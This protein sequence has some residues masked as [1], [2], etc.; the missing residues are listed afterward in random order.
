MNWNVEMQSRFDQLR[1]AELAG[2]L[3]PRE[4]SELT[5]LVAILEADE[6]HHLAPAITQM[7]AE[8][9]ALREQLHALQSENEEL[10]KLLSQQEQLVAD[11]RRWLT[12]FQQRHLL[13]L[14]AYTRL[15]GEVLVAPSS[16]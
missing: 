5:K 10:A 6:A 11:A 4:E 15:T 7:R 14:Q 1:A 12:Q 8:Q 13:I 2:R 3:T 9:T 16:S